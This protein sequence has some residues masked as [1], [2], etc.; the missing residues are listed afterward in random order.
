MIRYKSYKQV[1]AAVIIKHKLCLSDEET[2]A[3][4]Q[5]NPYLQYFAELAGYQIQALDSID[6]GRWS[7]HCRVCHIRRPMPIESSTGNSLVEH[8]RPD[9]FDGRGT[10]GEC[11]VM[12][13]S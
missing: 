10:V 5:K 3:Q 7:Q 13:A 6:T 8:Q 1:I 9:V 11:L 2:V 4:I 12:I